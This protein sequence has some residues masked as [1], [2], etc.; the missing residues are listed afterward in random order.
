MA[1]PSLKE[2]IT[3][4]VGKELKQEFKQVEENKGT[5]LGTVEAGKGEGWRQFRDIWKDL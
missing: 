5:M 4:W 3:S 1:M 2:F